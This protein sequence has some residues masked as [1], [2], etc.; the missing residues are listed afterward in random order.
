MKKGLMFFYVYGKNAVERRGSLSRR[1]KRT[2][3]L[4]RARFLIR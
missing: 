3:L 2:R 1:E 4:G